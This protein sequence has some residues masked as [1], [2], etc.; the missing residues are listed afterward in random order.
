MPGGTEP[1][2]ETIHNLESPMKLTYI[3]ATHA[4]G[5]ARCRNLKEAIHNLE[6]WLLNPPPS[7]KGRP[8]RFHRVSIVRREHKGEGVSVHL[9]WTDVDAGATPP[10]PLEAA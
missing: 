4:K 10:P 5:Q 3:D 8:M 7:E 9:Y 1:Q 2:L 6:S